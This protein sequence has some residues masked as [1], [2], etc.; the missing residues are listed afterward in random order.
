MLKE[1][2]DL[3]D[4]PG[5]IFEDEQGFEMFYNLAVTPW[6]QLTFDVQWVNP[7]VKSID[8]TVVLGTRLF[9]QF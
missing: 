4:Q 8:D 6:I 3:D 5:N 2:G 7:G 1:S 9:M